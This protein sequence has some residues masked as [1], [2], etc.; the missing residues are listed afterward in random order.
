[1]CDILES[2]KNIKSEPVSNS[3]KNYKKIP[4]VLK[5]LVKF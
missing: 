4:K 1:M 5:K 2:L 3:F